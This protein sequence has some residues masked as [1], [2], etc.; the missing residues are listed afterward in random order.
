MKSM[1]SKASFALLAAV[2]ATYPFLVVAGLDFANARTLGTLLLGVAVLAALT[3]GGH[4]SDLVTLAVLAA[5][6]AKERVRATA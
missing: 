3:S 2:F 1:L 4:A 5:G 6:S